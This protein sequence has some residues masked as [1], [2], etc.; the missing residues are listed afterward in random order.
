MCISKGNSQTE[1]YKNR[2]T[3]EEQDRITR[4]VQI[5]EEKWEAKWGGKKET[6][7]PQEQEVKEMPRKETN[8]E[9][10][11]ENNQ[12]VSRR[13][14]ERWS[15][16]RGEGDKGNTGKKLEGQPIRP[17]APPIGRKK[18]SPE[19]QKKGTYEYQKSWEKQ[20]PIGG[21]FRETHNL[22]EP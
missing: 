4:I 21:K 16:E 18:I 9:K 5:L 3:Q 19:S 7:K 22:T 11:T 17:T 10:E 14:G 13:Q 6:Y 12:E 2:E 8:T 15:L 1:K 20:I